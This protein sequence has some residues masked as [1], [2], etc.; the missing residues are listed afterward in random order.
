MTP[1]EARAQF[2]V[3][4]RLAHLNAGSLGPLSRATLDAMTERVRF[5]QEHGRA[6]RPWYDDILAT[7]S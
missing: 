7:R 3:L 5:D 6:G 2:P 4:E 1:A